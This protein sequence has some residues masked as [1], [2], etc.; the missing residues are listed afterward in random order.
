M[1]NKKKMKY[2][3]RYIFLEK[4]KQNGNLRIKEVVNKWEANRYE[5]SFPL[6]LIPFLS[7]L[8]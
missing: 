4:E 7:F 2:I 1:F 6:N 5:N 8:P 3:S